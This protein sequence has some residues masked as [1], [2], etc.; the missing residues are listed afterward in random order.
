[1]TTDAILSKLTTRAIGRRLH[2]FDTLPSTSDEIKTLA[3]QN[4]PHGTT[5]IAHHQSAGRGRR[6]RSFYSPEGDGIYMSILLSGPIPAKDSGR[7]T[8]AA[9]VAVARAIEAL[10]PASVQIKW[11]NDLLI[12]GKKLSG[13]LTEGKLDPDSG[14][15]D[16]AVLGIG[17]NLSTA[18]FPPE[19]Q[20]IATSLKM[21][22]GVAPDPDTL[23]A[24]IL[25][26]LEPVLHESSTVFLEEY[27]R[28]S[29]VL[30]KTVTVFRGAETFSARA[31]AIDDTGA[32]LVETE[33]GTCAL[34]SGE[35]SVRL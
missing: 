20:A 7:I 24:E 6:G 10:T 35:V 17:I 15:L 33:T 14:M 16:Y 29:A 13:I 26:R 34:S 32:L 5:V 22:T 4:A 18:D 21:A 23:V 9:A 1:M 30:G 25:N 19:L 27:R 2:I 28:R 3:E 8:C 12:N 11:V 31:V